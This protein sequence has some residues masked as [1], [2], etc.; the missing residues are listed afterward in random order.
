MYC[1]HCGER[2]DADA[3]FCPGCGRRVQAVSGLRQQPER[4]YRPAP[5]RDP[6]YGR[7]SGRKRRS[8]V[9]AGVQA[10]LFGIPISGKTAI[11]ILVILVIV[12]I[13]LNKTG[14][15]D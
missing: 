11:I 3:S 6:A 15:L 10:R 12:C 7:R 8:P 5:E 14:V 1:K 13:I 9:S 4:S 2:L